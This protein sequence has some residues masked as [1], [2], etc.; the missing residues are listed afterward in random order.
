[1]RKNFGLQ[2]NTTIQKKIKF[3][4]STIKENA[5]F[6]CID[7]K[8]EVEMLDP[9][10]LTVEKNYSGPVIDWETEITLDLVKQTAEH[11][12]QQK[13]LHK[14]YLWILLKRLLTELEKDSNLVDLK[15]EGQITVCGDVHGQYY[16][17][18]NIFS[19]NGWPGPANKY[20]FNGDLVDRGC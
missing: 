6:E 9:N 1:M 17:M 18:L 7:Y 15:V 13:K 3:L 19:I 8:D 4:K 11:L 10:K 12:K 14:K 2:K 16:D 20:V 5:F